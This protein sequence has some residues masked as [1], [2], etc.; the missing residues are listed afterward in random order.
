MPV[1]IHVYVYVCI[2][3]YIHIYIYTSHRPPDPLPA[4]PYPRCSPL[5]SP[6]P[7]PLRRQRHFLGDL[8]PQGAI[9]VRTHS[10][11]RVPFRRGQ[12]RPMQTPLR[13]C[14]EGHH[15]CPNVNKSRTPHA[16]GSRGNCHCTHALNCSTRVKM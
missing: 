9:Y 8:K 2:Y 12:A 16:N 3:T 10:H 13:S 4:T 7:S 1:H 11:Q 14:A 5:H 6:R 15:T